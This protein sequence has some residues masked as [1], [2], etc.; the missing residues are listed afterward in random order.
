[1]T[2]EFARNLGHFRQ[3]VP[4]WPMACVKILAPAP[5][6]AA[7]VQRT[8]DSVAVQREEAPEEEETA[9]TFV[10]RQDEEH[11]AH[12]VAEETENER[13]GGVRNGGQRP[14]EQ[15][16]QRQVGAAGGETLD[17]GDLHGILMGGRVAR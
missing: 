7:G 14:G 15:H 16:A 13:P 1:M 6:P 3:A 4:E 2:P 8:A 11:Q 12:A 5:A 9:Q 10:Q 17:G